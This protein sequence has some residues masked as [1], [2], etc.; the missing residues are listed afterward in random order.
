MFIFN[1][2]EDINQHKASIAS[3]SNLD[4]AL[5]SLKDIVSLYVKEWHNEHEVITFRIEVIDQENQ[6]IRNIIWKSKSGFFE[7]CYIEKYVRHLIN[8]ETYQIWV[9]DAYS[10]G[11]CTFAD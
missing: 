10:E 8:K 7:A 4:N 3:S 1:F 2:Y 9:D 6:D 5:S 11:I